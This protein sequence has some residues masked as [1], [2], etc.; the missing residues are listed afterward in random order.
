MREK[1]DKDIETF[2]RAADLH[3]VGLQA[4]AV[5]KAKKNGKNEAEIIAKDPLDFWFAQVGVIF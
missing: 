5:A 2:S 3:L 4:E 1:L